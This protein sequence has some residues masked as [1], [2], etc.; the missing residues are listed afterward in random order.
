MG[1]L[2]L[3]GGEAASADAR[4]LLTNGDFSADADANNVPDGWSPSS[5]QG[6][7]VLEEQPDGSNAFALSGDG[8]TSVVFRQDVDLE[9][10]TVYTLIGEMSAQ[11]LPGATGHLHVINRGWTWSRT[12]TPLGPHSGPQRYATSFTAPEAEGFQVV[13]R[14]A[15]ASGGTIRYHDLRLVEGGVEEVT[16]AQEAITFHQA[17]YQDLQIGRT[18]CDPLPEMNEARVIRVAPGETR[19]V[20]LNVDTS[21]LPPGEYSASLLLR[22]F[23]R[24]LPQKS[25]PLRLE[26]LP[27]RLP[28]LMPIATFNWDYARN[29]R[30]VEDL[31]AHHTNS[32]LL[33]TGP[34]M[35]FDAEG[36]VT[37][38]ADWS[39]YDPMLQVKL[40]HARE[41][42]GIIVFS[43]GI[44]RDFDRQMRSRH[45]WEF[46]S[47][48]WQ[49]AF[50]TWVAEFERHMREDIGMSHN[51][52][53]VQI[54]D[55]A[56]HTNAELSLQG[57][58][59]I[60]EVAP[61]MSLCMDGAQNPDEVRMLDPVVDL[62]IPHQSA[63]YTREWSEEL[64]EVYRKIAA[65]GK[66]VWTYTCST[67]MKS[68]SPL[69]YYRLKEWRV[70]DLGVSGSCYWAYNSWRG[71]PWDDFDGTIADC[72]SI[73]DGPDRPITSRRWEA[74]RDGREDYKA[75]HLLREVARI[76]GAET[77]ARVEALIDS[78]VAEVLATPQ[79]LA[80]F[81]RARARLLDVLVAHCG[82]GAP[83][84]SAAPEFTW[85]GEALRVRWEADAMTEGLLRYRIPGDA[86]WREIRFKEAGAHE[87][88]VTDL[89]PMRDVEWYL[90]WWDHRGATGAEL[91]GLRTDGWAATR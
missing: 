24:E 72:G 79:D 69:D 22:P 60:R 32:F 71:D 1:D 43:Y 34:R 57:G 28:D 61:E 27:V 52:Y 88:T 51:E 48:P 12:L 19:Q 38:E 49:N 46:M 89:P 83:G 55:E 8:E 54:W 47:E 58:L 16:F 29:E 18:V 65:A 14:H 3:A 45:G 42:G 74:T 50:R 76:Q 15:G 41:K 21:A 70:W 56:T 63:L 6:S 81:E 82:E 5:R 20:F 31:V 85:T 9:P 40:R 44:V 66:P 17:E 23:D 26:V 36:N 37:S 73:Y 86:R 62:W 75:M 35:G 80:V 87:A 10:G 84:L 33:S 68:L 25:I 30:Y 13:L 77:A 67:H 7:W 4:N 59:L 11:D 91:S 39:S 2:R 90:L 53:S 64:R 78:L